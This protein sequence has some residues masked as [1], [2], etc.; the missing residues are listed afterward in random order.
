[1]VTIQNAEEAAAALASDGGASA[2]H[3]VHLFAQVWFQK[4]CNLNSGK[5]MRTSIEPAKEHNI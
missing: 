1:M 5:H 2:S 3:A 4:V